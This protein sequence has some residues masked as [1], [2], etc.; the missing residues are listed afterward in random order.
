MTAL[1]KYE[2]LEA[3]A[4]YYDG[5]TARAR[6]VIVKFGDA[7][8]IVVNHDDLPITHWS[9]AGVRDISQAGGSLTLTPGYDGDERLVIEDRD[10]VAAIREVCPDLRQGRSISARSWRKVAIWSAIALT[11]V[12]LIVFEIV[13]SLADQMATLIPA[14]AE[15][16]MGAQMAEQFADFLTE[17]EDARFC[18]TPAG[19]VAL[20]PRAATVVSVA[21]A[22]KRRIV[23]AFIGMEMIE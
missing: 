17:G 4:A 7:S 22:L 16:A 14:E 15:I 5:E 19:D 20:A 2:R 12:Y 13:P 10:M 11:S 23:R 9:L 18:S 6:G 3:A 8:L 1:A 21:A